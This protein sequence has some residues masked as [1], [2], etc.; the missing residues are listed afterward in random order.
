[1]NK[2]K[3]LESAVLNMMKVGAAA[4]NKEE[5]GRALRSLSRKDRRILARES[6]KIQEKKA[7]QQLGESNGNAQGG[8]LQEHKG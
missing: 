5:L 7:K 2:K 4:Q 3:K 8:D 1:M 6:Q